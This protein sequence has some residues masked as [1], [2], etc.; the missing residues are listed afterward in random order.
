M[1]ELIG[2]LALI[3]VAFKFS[4]RILG[5]VAQCILVFLF[6]AFLIPVFVLAIPGFI[7]LMEYTAAFWLNIFAL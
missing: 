6:L 5:F 4:G 1:L 3:Y 2:L 7:L